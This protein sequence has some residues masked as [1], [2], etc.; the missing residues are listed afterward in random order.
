MAV[1]NITEYSHLARDGSGALIPAG[2]EPG[3]DEQSLTIGGS[4]IQSAAFNANT[5]FIYV[6]AQDACAL[7]IGVNPTAVA[8]HKRMAAGQGLW[9]GVF[10]GH[11]LAVIN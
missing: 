11:K 2:L 4:S 8:T 5:K 1:L 10:G 6:F 7:A 9:F 3:L